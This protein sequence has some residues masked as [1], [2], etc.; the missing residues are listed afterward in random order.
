MR[1]RITIKTPFPSLRATARILGVSTSEAERVQRMLSPRRVT[2][3][4]KRSSGSGKPGSVVRQRSH[5]EF[6][7]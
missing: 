3:P 7:A 1:R 5:S 2:R 6:D 4:R